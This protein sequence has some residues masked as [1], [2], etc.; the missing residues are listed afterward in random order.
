MNDTGLPFMT[1]TTS[2]LLMIRPVG[3]TFNE[4]T[5]GTNAFQRRET[6]RPDAQEQALREFNALV[7][8]LREHQIHVITIDDT[9]E[10]HTPDSIFP[11]NWISTHEDGMVVV[12]P[13]QS[14][15][16]RLERRADILQ[17][18]GE[19]Y[20]MYDIIDL[21]ANEKEQQFL[22][23]TGSMVL[24]RDTRI[25]YACLSP[26]THKSILQQFCNKLGYELL[27]FDAFDMQHQPIYHTNVIMCIG[28]KFMAICLECIPDQVQ[29]H[30]I[31]QSTSKEII[32]LTM[33][34]M[35]KFCGNML[36]VKNV[37]GESF[38]VMSSTAYEALRPDQVTRIEH[39]GHILH[40]PVSTIESHGGGSVRCM[41]A[42]VFL[43]PKKS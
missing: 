19:H 31:E 12:Y 23:G 37:K 14:L 6:H 39:Y 21:T 20:M 33:D 27:A 7:K 22:E 3:F 15:N 17:L 26:R 9:L 30:Q 41:L 4:E 10:P 28:E 36:E 24:D 8:L 5:A 40:S 18:L 43:Q 42:E 34:Q 1:Q 38:V 16:R 13:M 35:N 32:P 29:R 25:C 11:N 2:T